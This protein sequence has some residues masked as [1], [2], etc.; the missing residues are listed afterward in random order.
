MLMGMMDDARHWT[1]F[2]PSAHPAEIERMREIVDD[3]NLADAYLGFG[4]RPFGPMDREPYGQPIGVMKPWE[5][6]VSDLSTEPLLVDLQTGWRFW[7]VGGERP[8]ALDITKSDN[9]F[10]G[11]ELL[12]TAR[13]RCKRAPYADKLTAIYPGFDPDLGAL[14]GANPS[15]QTPP[16]MPVQPFNFRAQ[17]R[18][19]LDQICGLLETLFM[20]YGRA[21]KLWYR[22]Q[23]RERALERD[24]ALTASIYGV[25]RQPSLHPS[26]GRYAYEHPDQMSEMF[27]F[28]GPNHDWKKPFLIWMMRENAHWFAHEPRCLD[29]LRDVLAQEDDLQFARLLSQIDLGQAAFGGPPFLNWPDEADDLRQWFFAHMKTSEFAITLQQYGYCTSLLDVTDDVNVALYFTQARMIERQMRREAPGAARVLYV[30]AETHSAGFFTRGADMFWG[31][32]GWSGRMPPRLER[33]KAGFMR[34][35]TNRTQNQCANAIVARI[36]LDMSIETTLMDEDLFPAR[37]A[38]LLLATLA[39]ARPHLEGL[40]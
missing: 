2:T 19:E 31:T 38:D 35:S 7:Y 10:D 34:G 15:T 24:P 28:H 16:G 14:P 13:V 27:A 6:E 18:A 5:P 12:T 11:Q 33:Q 25:D 3:P 17:D 4:L 30:M 39:D 29:M 36:H 20:T 8:L 26:L 22:G 21:R 32:D 40:Y 1:N 23:R 37:D 9:F